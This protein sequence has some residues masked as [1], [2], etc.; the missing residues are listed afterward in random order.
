ML[1]EKQIGNYLHT[2][3]FELDRQVGTNH[4]RETGFEFAWR[5]KYR[6]KPSFEPGIELYWAPGDIDNF[7]RSSEQ[8][9][10]IGPV[11]GGKFMLGN[12]RKLRYEV[13]YL[14]GLN[15]ATA[16]DTWKALLEYEFRF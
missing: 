4:S 7:K 5:S 13:G 11:I 1:L 2:A 16:R 8:E 12:K 10:S 15:D 9:L 14:H 6:L 3:N